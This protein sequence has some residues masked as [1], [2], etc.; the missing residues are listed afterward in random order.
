IHE[1]TEGIQGL[2]LLGRKLGS[3]GGKGYAL[4]LQQV[5]L[6]LEQANGNVLRQPLSEALVTLKE[7]TASLQRQVEQDPDHGLSNATVYLDLFGGV[8]VGWVWLRQALV[9]TQALNA[10]ASGGDADFYHGKV[11]TASYSMDWELAPL[12]G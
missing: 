5:E 4:F 3:K 7:V 6:T 10:G 11:H 8:V 2:D 1:G 12:A 9:A